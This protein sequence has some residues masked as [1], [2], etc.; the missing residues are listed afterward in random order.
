MKEGTIK[1][2]NAIN[3]IEFICFDLSDIPDIGHI[4]SPLHKVRGDILRRVVGELEQSD[5]NLMLDRIKGDTSKEAIGEAF[6]CTF[7][8][9]MSPEEASMYFPELITTKD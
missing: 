3:N 4:T 2:C 7:D 9:F 1:L 5:I 8:V 6:T